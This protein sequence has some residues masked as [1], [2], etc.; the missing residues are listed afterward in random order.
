MPLYNA[1]RF[2]AET[3]HSIQNQTYKDYELI[4]INDA[5]TDGTLDIL[6]AVQEKDNRIQIYSNE[7]HSGAAISRN[8]GIR[9][10]KGEYIT[11]LDGD[12]IFD[13]E[14]LSLAY[15]TS[16][17]KELDVLMY[18]YKHVTSEE[19]YIKRTIPRSEEYVQRYCIKPFSIEEQSPE[20]FFNWTGAPW[21][22]LYRKDFIINNKL[23]FQT[24]SCCNDVYFVMMALILAERVMVLNDRRVMVYARDHFTPTRISYDRDP[25]CLYLA[26]EKF[27]IEIINRG[28]LPKLYEHY[29]FRLYF[30][31]ISGFR[32]AK[33]EEKKMLFYEFLKK[34]GIN[35][36]RELGKE[37]YNRLDDTVKEMLEHFENREYS[38]KWYEKESNFSYFLKKN[39]FKVIQLFNQ[40][41]NTVIW[42]AGINGRHLLRFI[43]E[44]GIVV[45]A[46]VDIDVNKQGTI[47]EGYQ[48]REPETVIFPAGSLIVVS[49]REAYIDVKEKF[50]LD[51]IWVVFIGDYIKMGV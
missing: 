42:G 51:D 14:M 38:S 22:K 24:L 12:D 2:L 11:F 19:I 32:V 10:A 39:A 3:L 18:E 25:M 20:D 47:I 35:R 41:E 33:S 48:V 23:E 40:S 50:L 15:E 45:K 31:L 8:K 9:K 5:S 49:A 43:N 6:K 37:Y 29:Y 34:E 16:K 1:E 13:E 46:L 27:L 28:M 21:N 36:L 4:C 30:L 17:A 44:N 26:M 7:K